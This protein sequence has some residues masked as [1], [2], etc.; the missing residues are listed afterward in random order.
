M[1]YSY[2]MT[3]KDGTEWRVRKFDGGGMNLNGDNYDVFFFDHKGNM[4]CALQNN[5][6]SVIDI[7]TK[8][9]YVN[10]GNR[11]IGKHPYAVDA[12]EEIELAEFE[13]KKR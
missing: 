2:L 5:I 7:K 4:R 1:K 6:V 3:M 8:K 13:G 9:P 12:A 11:S 10:F